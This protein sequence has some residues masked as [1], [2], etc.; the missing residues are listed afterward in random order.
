ME[1]IEPASH[2]QSPCVICGAMVDLPAVWACP[3]GAWRL[4]YRSAC[5]L[6]IPR[7]H[8]D[9]ACGQPATLL[10]W[11]PARADELRRLSAKRRLIWV[12]S[13]RKGQ[14]LSRHGHYAELPPSVQ[15]IDALK[16]YAAGPGANNAGAAVRWQM[17]DHGV[18]G[19]SG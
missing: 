3:C 13:D 12:A 9:G 14:P 8:R 10:R 1:T 18:M 5:Q 16:D 7:D 11:L 4:C 6:R 17:W 2:L 19:A 15:V